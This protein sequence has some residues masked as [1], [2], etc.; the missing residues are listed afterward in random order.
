MVDY[1]ALGFPYLND[2]IMRFIGG[3]QLHGAKLEGSDD[4][5]YYGIFIE[6]LPKIC[7]LDSYEHFVHTTGGK[8]GGNGPE[9]VDITFYS[10]RKWAKLAAKG[11]PSIMHFLFAEPAYHTEEWMR[12]AV[13][14]E[15]FT[16]K[17]HA[18][19]FF[20]YAHAQLQRLYGGRGQKN[21]KRQQ[22]ETD[23]GY[24]TKYAMHI[25]RLLHEGIELMEK[26]RITLPGPNVQ[27]LIDIRRGI[28]KLPTVIERATQLEEKLREAE[29]KSWLPEHVDRDKI[30]QLLA[31]V[32]AD[33]WLKREQQQL[34]EVQQLM[35]MR[36][37]F[38]GET[39]AQEA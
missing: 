15:M 2:V 30:S 29:Q 19:A 23:Y 9:D 7:G 35:R 1:E 12:I 33:H 10:L 26:G 25:V 36:G 3:S 5:D 16:A 4:T 20:G 21:C 31:E 24:D 6:P 39:K 37:G 11:N 14:W 17:S 34:R 28:Y 38:K 22:L 13:N 8:P 32:Y 27:E 18:S